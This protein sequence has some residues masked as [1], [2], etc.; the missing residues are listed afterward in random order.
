M[1]TLAKRAGQC[2]NTCAWVVTIVLLLFCAGHGLAQTGD[3][4]AKDSKPVKVNEMYSATG[5]GQAG[6][7]GGKSIQLNLYINGYTSDAEAQRLAGILKDKGP[8]ELEKALNKL[9]VGRVSPVASTGTVVSVIRI[10]PA[11]NGG[12]RIIMATNRPIPFFEAR[13]APRSRDY[14]F[15][16]VELNLD[17]QGKGEG[18]L[19]AA[20]KLSFNKDGELEVEH[21]GIAPVRLTNVQKQR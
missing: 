3:S 8:D 1:T 2:C 7:V 15:G 13:N 16:L 18:A 20:A 14:K 5:F 12:K 6:A 9:N 19:Y 21:F 17:S 4:K 10:H 11:E